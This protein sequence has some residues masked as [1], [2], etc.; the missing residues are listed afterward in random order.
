M[1][2][3]SPPTTHQSSLQAKL[4]QKK[5]L[6]TQKTSKTEQELNQDVNINIPIQTKPD[7]FQ[8]FLKPFFSRDPASNLP[9]YQLQNL[10]LSSRMTAKSNFISS[11]LDSLNGI[12]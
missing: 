12:A 6:T 1:Y 8:V 5:Q 3:P 4:T 2:K 11:P 7:I 9:K 10:F